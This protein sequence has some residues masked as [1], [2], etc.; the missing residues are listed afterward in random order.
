MG[1]TDVATKRYLRN[2][3][4]FADVFNYYLYGGEQVIQP[5]SLVELDSHEADIPYGADG[6]PFPVERMRD[7]IKSIV[8]MTDGRTAYR[9]LAIESQTRVHYA[10][11]VRD[12]IYTGL[13]YAEQIKEATDSH[14]EAGDYK[15]ASPDEYLS[16]FMKSDRLL[17]VLTVVIHFSPSRWDGPT[18]LYEMFDL[19]E[20]GNKE[21]LE[22]IP[23]HRINLLDPASIEDW[24]LDK[25][26][27]TLK[28]ILLIIKYS[29]RGQ[30]EKMMELLQ[31]EDLCRDFGR[32][33][34][35]VL[36]FCV[37]TGL[38]VNKGKEVKDVEDLKTVWDE[39]REEAAAE[40]ERADAA[41][42]KLD[43]TMTELAETKAKL[44][45]LEKRN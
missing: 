6:A 5:E 2:N 12:M 42:A 1:G 24:E 44:A 21:L 17:P 27:S 16:G 11:P 15:G 35:D 10:M 38:E 25:F 34:M 3:A 40:K 28:G 18:S 23:D 33:E 32:D 20:E 14:K 4:I 19:E 31:S 26:N 13:N 7:I 36:N 29:G 45:A 39:I 8:S 43:A 30:R 22:F 37:H 41:I 9:I